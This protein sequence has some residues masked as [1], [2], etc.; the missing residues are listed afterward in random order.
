[1]VER[2]NAQQLVAGLNKDVAF[3][4]KLGDGFPEDGDTENIKKSYHCHDDQS[5]TEVLKKIARCVSEDGVR[6]KLYKETAKNSKDYLF[7]S[8]Y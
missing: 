2:Q 1:M 4:D 3:A 7:P 5:Y 6:T 8:G